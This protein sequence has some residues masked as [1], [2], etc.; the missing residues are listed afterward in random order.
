MGGRWYTCPNGHPFYVDL[1]GRPTVVQK[2]AECG[3]DIGGENH[4]LLVDNIDLGNVGTDYYQNT[5]LEDKSDKN[6]CMRG[7]AEEAEDRFFSARAMNPTAIRVTRLVRN[8]WLTLML[9]L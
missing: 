1:C 6:Y 2:C 8:S 9:N 5:V 7:A 3:V 4:D